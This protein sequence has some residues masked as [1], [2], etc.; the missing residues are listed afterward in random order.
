MFTDEVMHLLPVPSTVMAIVLS[1]RIPHSFNQ[2]GCEKQQVKNKCAA[3]KFRWQCAIMTFIQTVNKL[4]VLGVTLQVT[5]KV[6][7]YFLI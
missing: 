5:S 6:T 2:N 4:L 1:F 3:R 7:H